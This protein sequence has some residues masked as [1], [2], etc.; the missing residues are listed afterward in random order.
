[1][2]GAQDHELHKR[3]RGRNLV[4]GAVLLGLVALIFAVTLVKLGQNVV[5]PF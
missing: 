5:K 4:V 2:S 1:M 3:R